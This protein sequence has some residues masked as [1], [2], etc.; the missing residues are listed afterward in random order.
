MPN[1]LVLAE[2]GFGKT[3]SLCPIPEIGITGLNAEESFI[4]SAT[5]KPLP[6]RSSSSLYPI[7]TLENIKDCRRII[8]NDA[9]TVAQILSVLSKSPYKNIICDDFN[10]LMQD[11]YMKKAMVGG[12]DTPKVIGYSMGLI[13]EQLEILSKLNKNIIVLAHHEGYKADNT[14]NLSFRM[15]TVGRMVQ[16]YITPEGKFD[17]VLFGKS[18]FDEKTKKSERFF[19]TNYDGTYNA[20]SPVGMFEDIYIPNDMG[21][22]IEKVNQYYN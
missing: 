15:K 3:T 20:K 7:G 4:V 11:Y 19:V 14:E 16:E 5:A 10:Y 21:L 9:K 22:V 17:I 18:T 1:I 12:W 13:F 2:S 8:S 6:F